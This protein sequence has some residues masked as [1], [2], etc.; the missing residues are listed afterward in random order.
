[1]KLLFTLLLAS[2]SLLSTAQNKFSNGDKAKNFTLKS[3]TGEK[4]KLSELNSEN[5]VVLIVLRGWPE[6]QCPVSSRLVGEFIAEEEKLVEYDVNVVFVYPGPSTVLQEKAKEFAEDFTFPDNFSFVLDPDYS[7][8]NKYGLR[9]DTPKETA[10]PTTLV[11]NKK[12]EIVYSKVSSTHRGRA[13][14]EEVLR[15]LENMK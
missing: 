3:I 4:V 7:M 15:A 9:W 6:Y 13:S 2:V 10:Y 11:I 14:A 1:M 12:S 8:I 5:P